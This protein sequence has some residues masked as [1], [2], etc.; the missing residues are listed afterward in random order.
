MR[1]V[2]SVGAAAVRAGANPVE[3]AGLATA[4][5]AGKRAENRLSAPIFPRDLTGF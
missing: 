4:W 3:K 2:K 1:F 5:N